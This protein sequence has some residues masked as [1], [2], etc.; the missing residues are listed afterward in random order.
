MPEGR[1]EVLAGQSPRPVAA[2]DGT[3]PIRSGRVPTDHVG[4]CARPGCQRDPSHPGGLRRRRVRDVVG[5]LAD[6]REELPDRQVRPARPTHR[7]PRLQRPVLHGV[8]RRRQQEGARRRPG[9]EPV[10]RHP[11]GR[12]GVDRRIQRRRDVPDHD[13][14]HLAS[15][16]PWCQV[17]RAG[18]TCRPVGPDGGSLPPRATG[19]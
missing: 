3:R 17:D 5:C 4:R 13:E 6:E 7:E 16:R 15:P 9:S 2:A 1:E 12:C 8:G 19:Q 10:E 11:A 14:L 18:S